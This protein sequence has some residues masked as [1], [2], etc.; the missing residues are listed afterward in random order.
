MKWFQVKIRGGHPVQGARPDW[1]VNSGAAALVKHGGGHPE[2]E[3]T[4]CSCLGRGFP[5]DHYLYLKEKVVQNGRGLSQPQK[6]CIA[7]VRNMRT[8]S[9]AIHGP[10]G[11]QALHAIRHKG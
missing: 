10:L 9:S 2:V 1:D 5:C 8:Q 3:V 11:S 4:P 6:H 7:I